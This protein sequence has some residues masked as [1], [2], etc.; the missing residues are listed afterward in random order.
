ME[1]LQTAPIVVGDCSHI[2]LSALPQDRLRMLRAAL[3]GPGDLVNCQISGIKSLYPRSGSRDSLWPQAKA[4]QDLVHTLRAYLIL[5]S[6]YRDGEPP[7]DVLSP[8]LV[9]HSH[10]ILSQNCICANTGSEVNVV[11]SVCIL[12]AAE[13]RDEARA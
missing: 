2:G 9:G 1:F 4:L 12:L 6:D 11:L 7:V 8:V 10:P 5:G 3:C 13:H